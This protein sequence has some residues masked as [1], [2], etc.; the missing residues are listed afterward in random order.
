MKVAQGETAL[1][2]ERLRERLTYD[3]ITGI[4]HWLRPV[5]RARYK[6]GDIAGCLKRHLGYWRIWIDNEEYLAHRLAWLYV[7]GEWPDGDLDH[8]NRNRAD[9]RWDNLRQ[10]T[11][12][13]NKINS[14]AWHKKKLPRGVT[15]AKR[16]R[17]LKKPYRAAI[18]IK[19][20]FC[21][22]GYFAS[23]EE[24]SAAYEVAALIEH[25]SFAA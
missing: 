19:D 21:H 17:P 12:S 16:D 6:E 15:F 4:F 9:N 8:K 14:P 5:K 25:G 20:K 10:A 7:K 18:E 11:V 3:P 13:Q 1:T 2:A 22:L 24:A 23:P